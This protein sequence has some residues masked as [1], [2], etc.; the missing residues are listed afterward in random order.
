MDLCYNEVTQRMEELM[1]YDIIVIG[2]G[3]A[4]M[5]AALYAARGGM[6]VMVLEKAFVGGQA[7]LTFEIENYP[8]FE[9]IGGMEL[10]MQMQ[11]QCEKFGV[12][13]EF[14]EVLSFELKNA[15]K[16][17]ETTAGVFEADA[18]ILALGA[19]A[20]KLEIEGE[21]RFTGSGVSYCATCDGAFYRKK[22]VAVVGGG[23]TAL[24]DAIYLSDLAEKVFVIHRRDEFRAS[25]VLVERARLR[26]NITFL[27]DS[28]VEKIEGEM[29]V[30]NIAVKNVKSGECSTIVLDGVFVAVGLTPET[31]LLEGVVEMENGYVLTDEWMKTSLPLVYAAGDLRKKPLRQV[32]TA[33]ADGA[34]AAEAAAMALR[35]KR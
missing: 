24:E 22:T 29:K 32:V 34:I 18:I 27:L 28:V 7:S 30:E 6:R 8:G 23:N 12:S 25:P 31:A 20:R 4:G 11:A 3:P 2:A 10:S 19:H 13:F 35:E 14:A 1:K 33:C 5:T 26:E 15:V 16:T 17:V 9:K 21:E